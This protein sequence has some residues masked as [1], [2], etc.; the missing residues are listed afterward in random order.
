MP[1]LDGCLLERIALVGSDRFNGAGR[2]NRESHEAP[3]YE[4]QTVVMRSLTLFAAA[5]AGERLVKRDEDR[6]KWAFAAGYQQI[7]VSNVLAC[8][9]LYLNMVLGIAVAVDRR[10]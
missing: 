5:D 2:A 9:N 7:A 6:W 10:Q 4:L 1:R 3:L 8:R